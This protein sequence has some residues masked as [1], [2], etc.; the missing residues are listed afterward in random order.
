MDKVQRS[1]DSG[2][3]ATTTAV[4][5]RESR[6]LFVENIRLMEQLAGLKREHADQIAELAA[7]LPVEA[8]AE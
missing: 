4:I 5:L 7:R 1:T 2:N 8:A 6:R 3:G